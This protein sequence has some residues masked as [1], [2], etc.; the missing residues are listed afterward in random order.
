MDRTG[1]MLHFADQAAAAARL[2]AELSLPCA[3]IETRRFPDGET[4][5]RLPVPLPPRALLFCTLG[6]PDARLV[7]LMLAARTAREHRVA[8]LTLIAPY[9]CYMRQDSAFRPGEAVSQRIVGAFL[10]EH[11]QLTLGFT[12]IAFVALLPK[13]LIG[14]G[15]RLRGVRK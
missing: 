13:G 6:S 2:A 1:V 9:L 15:E 4:L 10:G 14:L 12:I 3:A 5:L 8:H 7:E 11:W